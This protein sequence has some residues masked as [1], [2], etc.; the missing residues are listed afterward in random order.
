MIRILSVQETRDA[1]AAADAAGLGYEQMMENA[2][3]AVAARGLLLVADR[4]EAKITVLVGTGNNGGDG[5]VAGRIMAEQRADILVRFYLISRRE[6]ANFQKVQERGLLTAVMEDDGDRR[7]LRHMVASA[8]LIIDALYGIGVRLPLGGDGQTLLRGVGQ[9]LRERAAARRDR[10]NIDPTAPEQVEKP[11]RQYVLAVDCPSG[12]DCDSGELDKNTLTADETVT[13]IAAKPGLVTFPGAGAVGRL[14]VA[15]LDLPEKNAALDGATLHLLDHDTVRDLLPERPADGHKGTFGKVM[16]AAGSVN[17]TGA[18]ALTGIAAYRSGAGLVTVASAAPVAAVLG[19]HLLEVTWLLLPHDMGVISDKAAP[20]LLNELRSYQSLLVGPGLGRETTTRDFVR[21]L[22]DAVPAQPRRD[23]GF[24]SADVTAAADHPP[25][26]AL[27]PLVID[28]DGLN[29]LSELE[30]WHTLLP[31]N[32]VLTPHPGEMQRL[33]A[34]SDTAAV[35]SN[36]LSLTREKA[37]QWNAVVVLKG[38]HTL[39]ASPGGEIAVSPF[40][41][42]ALATAGTGDVLAGLIA[43]LMAQGLVPFHAAQVG[44]YVHGLA[45]VMAA[46]RRGSGRGVTAADVADSLAEALAVIEGE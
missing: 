11:P 43:G 40:K 4:P 34:L 31:P 32:T 28:A 18:A 39:V 6:D 1:E 46:R 12:L 13:F 22:L 2:G 33:A 5:L 25:Q 17:Y 35:Q 16:I 21:G 8:D 14:L 20:I 36:R 3:R 45:G 37:A 10:Q 19:T 7:V 27:P 26:G 41:T 42:D 30:N 24:G 23:I 38:A 9:A 15:K 29:L 44:V